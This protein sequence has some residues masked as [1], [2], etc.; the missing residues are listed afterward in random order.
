M[1]FIYTFNKKVA[2][3]PKVAMIIMI[4]YATLNIFEIEKYLACKWI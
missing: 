4:L 3:N 2:R 1:T